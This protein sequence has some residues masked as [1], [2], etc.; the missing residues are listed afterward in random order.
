MVLDYVLAHSDVEWLATEHDKVELFVD[1]FGVPRGDLP[2]RIFGPPPPDGE[3]TARYFPHKLPIAVVGEPPVPYFVSLATDTTGRGFEQF[4][5]SHAALLR[6]LPS[7]SV[8]AVAPR[9]SMALT[10][11]QD[12]FEQFVERPSSRLTAH[13]DIPWYFAARALVDRGEVKRLSVAD[14]DRF[15]KLRARFAVPAVETLYAEW[16][17]R[18]DAALAT[19]ESAASP[20]G[21]IR[22]GHLITD[23]LPFDYT[24]FGSLPG[25]A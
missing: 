8:I 11:C 7:W 6:R 18:G 9:S 14:I 15:R 13:V 25:V 2:Q 10:A 22:P 17:T 3:P 16:R 12:A 4:L 23:V 24:Q 1:R 20:L 5:F 19:R 21:T